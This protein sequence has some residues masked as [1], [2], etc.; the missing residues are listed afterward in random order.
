MEVIAAFLILAV[1]N[2]HEVKE[3]WFKLIKSNYNS[4]TQQQIR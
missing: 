2:S 1:F 3:N 4:S